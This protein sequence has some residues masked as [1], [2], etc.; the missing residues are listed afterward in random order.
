MTNERKQRIAELRSTGISYAK[1]GEAIGISGD[2]SKSKY[3][4]EPEHMI[5]WIGKQP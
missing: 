3:I 2:I 4:Y 1:I 5:I